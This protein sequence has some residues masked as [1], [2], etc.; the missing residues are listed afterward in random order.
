MEK[1]QHIDHD[2]LEKFVSKCN[3]NK[4][5]LWKDPRLWITIRLWARF[6]D[7]NEIVFIVLTRDIMQGW[8][9]TTIRRQIQTIDHARKYNENVRNSITEFLKEN[10]AMYY[11]LQYEDLLINSDRVISE[12]NQLAGTSLSLQDFRSV[13]RGVLGKKQHGLKSASLAYAIY[14]KNYRSRYR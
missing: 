2:Q 1:S 5:W 3:N 12:L 14:L 13:F 6:L 9:S 10:K 7:L 8:I 4:P 11:D